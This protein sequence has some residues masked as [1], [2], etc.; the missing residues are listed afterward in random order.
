MTQRPGAAQRDAT[1]VIIGVDV[2]ATSLSGG[3][4]T[5]DGEV[6]DVLERTTHGD[7]A[8]LENM[9][10]VIRSL[11]ATARRRGLDVEGVG[12]GLPGVVDVEKGTMLADVYLVPE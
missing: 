5:P 6:L 9:L 3:L 11:H 7:G 2:G 4:V 10:D 1:T 12:V 8:A